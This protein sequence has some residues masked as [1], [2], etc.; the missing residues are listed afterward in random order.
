MF[1]EWSSVV[2]APVTYFM[3]ENEMIEYLKD[4]YG[5][6]G[7]DENLKRIERAK[8]NGTSSY[9]YQNIDDLISFN[10]AGKNEENLTK[11]EIWKEY[12]YH[13]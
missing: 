5:S 9:M 6:N 2:D 10:R 11:E 7:I 3:Y 12:Q 4:A 13:G 8:Q 1:A